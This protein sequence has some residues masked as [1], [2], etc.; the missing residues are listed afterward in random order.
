VQ[1]G[2]WCPFCAGVARIY[3]DGPLRRC[4]KCKQEKDKAT[5][6]YKDKRKKDGLS[7]ICRDCHQVCV[8]AW[9]AKNVDKLREYAAQNYLENKDHILEL[10][11]E[12][13]DAHLEQ[14][15]ALSKSW[16]EDHKAEK[17]ERR[18]ELLRTDP[19][20]WL[21]HCMRGR[22]NAFFGSKKPSKTMDLLGCS[23][24]RLRAHIESQFQV[25]MTWE[26]KGQWHV[27]HIIPMAQININDPESIK[28]ICHYTNLQPLWAQD[29]LRKGART[30]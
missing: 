14:A 19:K 1:Q 17:H 21:I 9:A 15:R 4:S 20:A 26:N 11:K 30:C 8:A 6:F 13:H 5:C 7:S 23:L 24:E 16:Y 2:Y 10:N 12:W 28:R 3:S 25:G 27:D 29:N 18:M 22:L